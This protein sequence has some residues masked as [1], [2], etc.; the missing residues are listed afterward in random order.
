[1]ATEQKSTPTWR[2]NV[3]QNETEVNIKDTLLIRH[4]ITNTLWKCSLD[5]K[6][7]ECQSLVVTLDPW[8]ENEPVQQYVLPY[9]C[10]VKFDPDLITQP[11]TPHLRAEAIPRSRRDDPLDLYY[12]LYLIRV[13]GNA[14]FEAARR[15]ALFDRKDS[16][17]K[18]VFEVI[19]G[20]V[21]Y[22]LEDRLVS[23]KEYAKTL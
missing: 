14:R 20:K 7:I 9:R 16:G 6:L 4:P 18:C 2:D 21:H 13:P 12:P 3:I 11:C 17:L 22:E 19:S 15:L 23:E 1:M 5:A 8:K 10:F